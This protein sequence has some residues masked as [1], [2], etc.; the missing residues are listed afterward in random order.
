MKPISVGEGWMAEDFVSSSSTEGRGSRVEVLPG[1]QDLGA[2]DDLEYFRRKVTE[3]LAV[4]AHML[5]A[6]RQYELLSQAYLSQAEL[7]TKP[8][9]VVPADSEIGK[10]MV[11]EMRA[12][13]LDDCMELLE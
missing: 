5:Q 6:N 12:R 10:K 1:G 9:M 7:A 4:P 3:G 2:L 11:N 13:K 8:S